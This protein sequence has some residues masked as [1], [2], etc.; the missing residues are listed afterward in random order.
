MLS[1][2]QNF[3]IEQINFIVVVDVLLVVLVFYW[4]YLFIRRTR[5]VQLLKGVAVLVLVFWL[6]S[7]LGLEKLNWLFR[8][9]LYGLLVAIPIVFQPELR[10]ALEQLG[11]GRFV[12]RSLFA[13]NEVDR[14][15]MIHEVVRAATVLCSQRT[16]ALII[17]EGNTG[18]NDF[19]EGGIKIDGLVSAELLI[20]IFENNA[21][22]HDGAVIIRG[23]RVAAA[24]CVLPLSENTYLNKKLG[25]RHRAAIGI[26]EQTDALA[27]VVSEET[28]SLS[29]SLEGNLTEFL[30]EVELKEMLLAHLRPEQYSSLM[31]IWRK[32]Q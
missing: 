5:A 13:F 2:L 30:D 17:I 21:P 3:N 31:F 6:S 12:D 26:T 15:R 11:R 19:I 20:N 7:L 28:G 32:K 25:M 27:V 16:G 4:V 22:L 10:R 18:L 8:Q 29:L 14:T 1:Q 23:D 9:S 24:S